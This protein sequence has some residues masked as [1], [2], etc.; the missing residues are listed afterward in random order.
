[1]KRLCRI[2]P[3]LVIALLVLG[4]SSV[5]MAQ[6][7]YRLNYFSNNVAAAP[8]ATVRIDHCRP[9]WT[10]NRSGK[11]ENKGIDLSC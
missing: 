1:M 9:N 8:D 7:V 11:V 10:G 6:D 4:L 5:G 2:L 3:L